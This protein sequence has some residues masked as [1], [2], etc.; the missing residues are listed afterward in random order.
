M[1]PGILPPFEKPDDKIVR[2]PE[3]DDELYEEEEDE[4]EDNIDAGGG[5]GMTKKKKRKKETEPD[6]NDEEVVVE[7]AQEVR[8]LMVFI[9]FIRR[10]FSLGPIVYKPLHHSCIVLHVAAL[11]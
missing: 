2:L 9:W 10:V 4:G 3:L 6:E 1:A 7:F 8:R 5:A 11:L